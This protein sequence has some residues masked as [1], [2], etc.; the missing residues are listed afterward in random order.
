MKILNLSAV[1]NKL[2]ELRL[3]IITD[4]QC[5]MERIQ[6]EL[7]FDLTLAVDQTL[8]EPSIGISDK[9]LSWLKAKEA[10]G[11]YG[12]IV[13]APVAGFGAG[14]L[15]GWAV[16]NFWNPSGWAAFAAGVGVLA[17]GYAVNVGVEKISA[18]VEDGAKSDLAKYRAKL[19]TKCKEK[20]WNTYGEINKQNYKWLCTVI[21]NAKDNVVNALSSAENDAKAFVGA[22]E[23]FR[24]EL[25]T[26]RYESSHKAVIAVL[27]IIYPTNILECFTVTAAPRR[28]G[29][30]LKIVVQP[31]DNGS[32]LNR[33]IGSGGSKMRELETH[34]GTEKINLIERPY[35]CD[36][37]TEAIV[38]ALRPG[39]IDIKNIRIIDNNN[40]NNM[41]IVVSAKKD[42]ISKIMGKKHWNIRLAEA[43]LGCSIQ[44]KC[45][46]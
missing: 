15:F 14:I 31:K 4:I 38:A 34:C 28:L 46:D 37:D 3:N 30:R 17:G 13:G 18:V 39:I 43:A 29:Y 23:I 40:K 33:L 19:R 20:L 6:H 25:E 35:R 2:A 9:G 1:D 12:R 16:A 10:T 44:L 21:G 11:K 32:I 36:I 27:R 24:C 22:A 45:I 8:K 26:L 7:S 5:E 42:E 41:V